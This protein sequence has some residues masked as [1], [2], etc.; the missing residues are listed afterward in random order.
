M[1]Q[2]IIKYETEMSKAL[3]LAH[4]NQEKCNNLEFE[5]N[6]VAVE[7]ETTRKD[8]ELLKT[9]LKSVENEK[10]SLHT[11]LI[12][13]EANKHQVCIRFTD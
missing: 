1:L 5:K 6:T 3:D 8:I 11:N 13:L 7:L 12:K 10:D 9:K 4:T 2:K